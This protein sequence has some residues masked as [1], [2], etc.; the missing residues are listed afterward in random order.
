KLALGLAVFPGWTTLVIA[1]LCGDMGASLAVI[2]NAMRL[3]RFRPNGSGR[4]VA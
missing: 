2:G 1:V 3:A 4:K